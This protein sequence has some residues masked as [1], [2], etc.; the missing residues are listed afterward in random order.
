MTALYTA[1]ADNEPI[2]CT[3]MVERLRGFTFCH[4]GNQSST[5]KDVSKVKVRE[6]MF[7]GQKIDS[8]DVTAVHI[9]FSD[10]HHL[11]NSVFKNFGDVTR[12]KISYSKI[13]GISHN[14]F[15]AAKYLR[16]IEIED[17]Q[18]GKIQSKAFEL[19]VNL[20]E[21]SIQNSE[22]E[23][24]SADAFSGLQKLK[25]INLRNNTFKMLV[26]NFSNIPDTVVVTNN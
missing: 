2:E 17:S 9:S 26:P 6:N 13:K 1:K 23:N 14:D 8:Q 24:F 16:F 18:I 20:E 22:I 5:N 11:P 10:F 19:A 3:P 21:V 15:A 12:I 25:T 4:F 7:Q